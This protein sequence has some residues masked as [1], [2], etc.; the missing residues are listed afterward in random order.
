MPIVKVEDLV[1]GKVYVVRGGTVILKGGSVEKAVP[2]GYDRIKF[3]RTTDTHI[4]VATCWGSE[5]P[6]ALD[7]PL[8]STSETMMRTEFKLR[9]VHISR[10]KIPFDE[11]LKLGICK[12]L[13]EET[14]RVQMATETPD[15]KAV[16]Q[17]KVTRSMFTDDLIK[18][19]T[20]F[21][22]VPAAADHFGVKYQ[23]I[24]YTLDG[25]KKKG[26]NNQRY[27]LEKKVDGITQVKLTKV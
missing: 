21:N 5:V 24:R 9:G 3:L 22:S 4:I 16:T 23:K 6:L 17:S 25:I 2:W 19:F 8:H 1:Q 18:Y 26:Y 7:Y 13:D 10:K 11:A 14:L 20:E 12:E 27:I 15:I